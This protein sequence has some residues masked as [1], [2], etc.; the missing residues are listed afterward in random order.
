MDGLRDPLFRIERTLAAK[1]TPAQKVAASPYQQIALA[2]LAGANGPHWRKNFLELADL[3]AKEGQYV[4]CCMALLAEIL[5]AGADACSAQAAHVNGG[6]KAAAAVG[7]NH[8]AHAARG[9]G[10]TVE[11]A[12]AAGARRRKSNAPSMPLTSFCMQ[13]PELHAKA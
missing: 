5:V 8:A 3:A 4:T 7:A 12:P 2:V 13:H 6:A 10:K 1:G 9:G 11:E